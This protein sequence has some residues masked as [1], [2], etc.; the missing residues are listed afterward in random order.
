MSSKIF[1]ALH[2]YT[3]DFL[4]LMVMRFFI[5]VALPVRREIHD[6][7]VYVEFLVI[8]FVS[9]SAVTSP[10]KMWLHMRF[11]PHAGDAIILQNITSLSQA[12]NRSCSFSFTLSLLLRLEED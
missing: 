2:G 3:S 12:K 10:V 7:L 11:L 5:T 6:K 8:F 4:F 1:E 9:F